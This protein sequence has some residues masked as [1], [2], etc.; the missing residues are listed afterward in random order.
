MVLE[1]IHCQYKYICVLV[2]AEVPKSIS[3]VLVR[4]VLNPLGVTE[5]Q[6]SVTVM[7][8]RTPNFH[9]SIWDHIASTTTIKLDS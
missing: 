1:V 2:F 6:S 4:S 3:A 8:F 9:V 5:V 7:N